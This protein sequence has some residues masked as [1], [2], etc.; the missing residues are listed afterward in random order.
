MPVGWAYCLGEPTHPVGSFHY[1]T[2]ALSSAKAITV[3]TVNAV[4]SE[5]LYGFDTDSRQL[6]VHKKSHESSIR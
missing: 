4:E 5:F 1:R 2:F 3:N 6:H